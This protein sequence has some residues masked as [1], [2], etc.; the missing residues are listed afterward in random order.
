MFCRR[1]QIIGDAEIIRMN[2]ENVKI[3]SSCRF[4]GIQIDEHLNFDPDTKL[5]VVE[6]SKKIYLICTKK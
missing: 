6:V 4:L 2:G 5:V 1:L 3:V